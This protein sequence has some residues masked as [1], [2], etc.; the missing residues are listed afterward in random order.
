MALLYYKVN[1]RYQYYLT[2][3]SRSAT[4]HKSILVTMFEM[5]IHR[6]DDHPYR[7]KAIVRTFQS[8]PYSHLMQHA[9]T[10]LQWDKWKY[11][12]ERL[13]HYLEPTQ[14]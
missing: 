6:I 8:M 1:K 10:T 3:Q 5:L 9:F 14:L 4:P 7:Q 2:Q 11:E 13:S 12:L